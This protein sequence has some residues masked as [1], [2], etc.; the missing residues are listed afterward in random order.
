[1]SDTLFTDCISNLLLRVSIWIHK[2]DN[3]AAAEKDVGHTFEYVHR[4]KTCVL[5]GN[6]RY[7]LKQTYES[8]KSINMQ[9]EQFL[10]IACTFS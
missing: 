6:L 4:S 8:N 10:L 7:F 9:V 5:L 1:M 2:M 3:H